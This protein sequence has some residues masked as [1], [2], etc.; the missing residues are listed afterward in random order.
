VKG[1]GEHFD[2]QGQFG[3]Y[4]VHHPDKLVELLITVSG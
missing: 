3:C 1:I 2:G 4:F